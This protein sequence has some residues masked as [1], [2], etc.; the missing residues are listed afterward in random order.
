MIQWVVDRPG[1]R[2]GLGNSAE[3]DGDADL[4]FTHPYG[5]LPRQLQRFK[6]MIVNLY[7][8]KKVLAEGWCGSELYPISKWGRGLTNTMYMG[9]SYSRSPVDLTGYIEDE[10]EPGRGWFPQDMVD[11]LLLDFMTSMSVCGITVFDGFMGRGTVG[12][13]CL[14][15]DCE[16]VGIDRDPD[17]IALAREYLGC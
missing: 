14:E 12:R 11:E 3:Y 2:L 9:G 10:F 17:R 1:I 13:A 6:P 8:D 15:L 4:V 7:G 16:Y 5:P